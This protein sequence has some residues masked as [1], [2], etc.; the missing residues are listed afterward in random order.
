[1]LAA[2]QVVA[3]SPPRGVPE[4]AALALPDRVPAQDDVPAPGEPRANLLVVS[5]SLPLGAVPAR[6]QDRRTP[7][8]RTLRHIQQCGHVEAGQA[9]EDYLLDPVTL[10]R[11]R[12]DD[13][14]TER[15]SC[16]RQPADRRRQPFPR[17][18]LQRIESGRVADGGPLGHARSVL[19]PGAI[20]L[21]LEELGDSGA[22]GRL[23]IEHGESLGTG[24]VGRLP[25][26]RSQ[27]HAHERDCRLHA[28]PPV[29][30]RRNGDRTRHRGAAALTDT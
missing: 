4:L 15:C 9:L 16:A 17:P 23:G 19:P 14:R 29:F 1:M 12:S 6:H 24:R 27:R 20:Q 25:R 3:A 10:A 30:R 28:S 26:R 18:A 21:V 8:R 11:Q 22:G 7:A 2:D 5:E 13:A